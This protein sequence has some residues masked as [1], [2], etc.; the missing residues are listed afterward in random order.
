MLSSCFSESKAISGR[1]DLGG[2]GHGSVEWPFELKAMAQIKENVGND[3]SCE[4]VKPLLL[5]LY[6]LDQR[7]GLDFI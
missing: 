7:S 3:F 1:C 4:L 2:F 5:L 6:P